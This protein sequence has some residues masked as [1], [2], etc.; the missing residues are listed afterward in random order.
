VDVTTIIGKGAAEEPTLGA[1][2]YP[3]ET[4]ENGAAVLIAQIKPARV[5][6]LTE[7]ATRPVW[8]GRRKESEVDTSVLTYLMV[9]ESVKDWRNIFAANGNGEPEALPCTPENKRTLI[10]NWPRFNTVWSRVVQ[11]Y[12]EAEQEREE[13]RAKNS[14]SG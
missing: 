7:Q 14:T 4:G 1:E 2:W 3:L 9:E 11:G 8:R 13:A 5:S 12:E 10:D 6:E